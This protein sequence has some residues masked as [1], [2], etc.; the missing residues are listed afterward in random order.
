MHV[1]QDNYGMPAE[2]RTRSQTC[3]SYA[4]DPPWPGLAW[5][6]G[7]SPLPFPPT[8]AAP[9]P[10]TRRSRTHPRFHAGRT[11]ACCCTALAPSAACWTP[12]PRSWRG[13][14]AGATRQCWSSRCGCGVGERQAGGWGGGGEKR[15][16][17]LRRC[18]V[19]LFTCRLDRIA[20]GRSMLGRVGGG[21]GAAA[22]Q[23]GVRPQ[24]LCLKPLLPLP[25]PALTNYHVPSAPS[26]S[27]VFP[28][29][30]PRRPCRRCRCRCRP[31]PGLQPSLHDARRGAGRGGRAHA[32]HLPAQRRRARPG[33]RHCGRAARPPR[34]RRAAQ[35]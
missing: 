2:R 14:A 24:P 13:R 25:T 34:L 7:R 19:A 9:T 15:G 11:S 16:P 4:P 32:A 22:P 30:S 28:P 20:P 10:S 5:P 6:P 8:S 12:L 33:G 26:H 23:C 27:H 29:A 21:G 18:A 17:C 1:R 3:L 35:H 31:P